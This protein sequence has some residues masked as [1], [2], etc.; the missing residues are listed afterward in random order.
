MQE[1]WDACSAAIAARMP[2]QAYKTWIKPLPSW[3]SA[4]TTV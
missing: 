4:L 3:N 1:Q 2:E